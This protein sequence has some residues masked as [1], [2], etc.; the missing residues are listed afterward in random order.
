MITVPS[1]GVSSRA[2][3]NYKRKRFEKRK[4]ADEDTEA[5][6]VLSVTQNTHT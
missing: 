1:P 2:G 6:S 4:K 5:V 3:G